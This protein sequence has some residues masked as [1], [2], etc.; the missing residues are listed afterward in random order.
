MNVENQYNW[1][2]QRQAMREK[3]AR[4][5]REKAAKLAR[6]YRQAEI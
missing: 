6:E 4:E 5:R 1:Q 3:L 2:Q